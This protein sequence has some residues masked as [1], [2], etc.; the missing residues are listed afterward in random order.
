[1][2]AAR[3]LTYRLPATREPLWAPLEFVARR[4][5]VDPLHYITGPKVQED[6]FLDVIVQEAIDCKADGAIDWANVA[7]CRNH[8]TLSRA[9]KDALKE[10]LGIPVG[11]VDVDLNDHSIECENLVKEK[12]EDF[13]AIME[14]RK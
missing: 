9:L 5:Y 12:L 13:I 6:R 1:M 4:Q 14:S 7:G 10:K 11:L 3:G 8:C 2:L